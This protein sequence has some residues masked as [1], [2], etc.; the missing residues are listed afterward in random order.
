MSLLAVLGLVRGNGLSS[1]TSAFSPKSMSGLGRG[2][3]LLIEGPA[4]VDPNPLPT[5][6]WAC[7]IFHVSL[8]SA[9]Y[10]SPLVKPSRLYAMHVK[11]A[12]GMQN[13]CVMLTE[14]IKE[15]AQC[16]SLA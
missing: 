12:T 4:S 6:G 2:L 7:W 14:L 15:P 13:D 8:G 10:F 9:R 16:T 11:N 5:V 3:L 1:M